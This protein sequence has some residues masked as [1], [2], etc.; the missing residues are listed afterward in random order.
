M[1]QNNIRELLRGLNN[2]GYRLI[3]IEVGCEYI[4]SWAVL[5]TLLLMYLYLS[6]MKSEREIEEGRKE[7]RR[8]RGQTKGREKGREPRYFS[9]HNHCSYFLHSIVLTM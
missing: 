2:F 8:K 1:L 7:K 6:L 5:H 3:I 4:W 9:L